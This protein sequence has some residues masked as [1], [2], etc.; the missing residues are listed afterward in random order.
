MHKLE[1]P[2]HLYPLWFAAGHG[3]SLAY[4]LQLHARGGCYV[5]PSVTGSS[6]P[7]DWQETHLQNSILAGCFLGPL[8]VPNLM[9][10]FFANTNW[11]RNSRAVWS[12]YP[13]S[14]LLSGITCLCSNASLRALTELSPPSPFSFSHSQCKLP[15]FL[16]VHSQDWQSKISL[17]LSS[18]NQQLLCSMIS[19]S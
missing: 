2:F 11:E 3:L 10:R 17:N 14:F 16:C 7:T 8:L 6:W 13:E 19:N 9:G 5:C 4:A 12:K 15:V 18:N 1:H